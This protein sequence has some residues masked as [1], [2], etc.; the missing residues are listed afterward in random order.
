M[1]TS[2]ESLAVSVCEVSDHEFRLD[3]RFV[4]HC[5]F[6]IYPLFFCLFD[7]LL[8]FLVCVST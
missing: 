7:C 4:R 5:F 6:A 8:V 2:N 1:G 3:N